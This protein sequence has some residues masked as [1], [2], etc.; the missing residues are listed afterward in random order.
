MFHSRIARSSSRRRQLSCCSKE[1]Q[2]QVFRDLRSLSFPD[3]GLSF[4]QK[5][6][7]PYS[8]MCNVCNVCNALTCM[9][10]P[11]CPLAIPL[12][13]HFHTF[14]HFCMLNNLLKN[15][16]PLLGKNTPFPIHFTPTFG[17]KNADFSLA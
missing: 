2:A 7:H 13:S 12:L 5:G 17:H 4:P 15:F 9:S 11:Y 16:T 10:K 3:L 8:K 6:R 1:F 14:T